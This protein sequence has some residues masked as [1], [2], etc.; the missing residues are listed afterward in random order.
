MWCGPFASLFGSQPNPASED[1]GRLERLW[2]RRWGCDNDVGQIRAALMHR[3]GLE[4]DVID[5]SKRIE[6]IGA[7]GDLGKGWYWQSDTIP[8][9][10]EIQQQHDSLA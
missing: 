7:F 5:R 4:F 8:P 2:G 6:E 10:A 9:L 1:P 3:P